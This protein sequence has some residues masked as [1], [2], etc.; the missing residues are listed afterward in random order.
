[1]TLAAWSRKD[2]PLVV[3]HRGAHHAAPENTLAAFRAAAAEGADAVE[4]DSQL[5]ASGEPVVFHDETLGRMCGVVGLVAERTLAELRALRVGGVEPFP[6]LAEALDATSLPV[7]VELK[8]AT[9]AEAAPLAAAA[10]RVVREAFAEARVLFSSFHPAALAAVARELPAVP[11]GLLL[12]AD[13]PLA[14][15]RSPW[16]PIARAQA[17]H[18]D[19]ALATRANVAAWH[20]RGY[21]VNA[22]TVNDDAVA[23]RLCAE[24]V[25]A[26]ITNRPA[27]LRRLVER[28][29]KG[30]G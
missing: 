17:V 24:G 20:R 1:M 2:R 11:R 13:A 14:F 9:L 4:L 15:G 25:D 23:E 26:L 29:G 19:F 18:P 16:E 10:A 22:W 28:A 6:L 12:E 21:L 27:A 5:C 8:C 7:N 30:G 3:A